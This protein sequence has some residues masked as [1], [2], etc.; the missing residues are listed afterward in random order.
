MS[1]LE[2]ASEVHSSNTITLLLEAAPRRRTLLF[3]VIFS[4]FGSSIAQNQPSKTA[5]AQAMTAEGKIGT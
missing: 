1:R 4:F 2:L 5:T 3:A